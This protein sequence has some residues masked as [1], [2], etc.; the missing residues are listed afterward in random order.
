MKKRK[1]IKNKCYILLLIFTFLCSLNVYSQDK[2]FNSVFTNVGGLTIPTDHYPQTMIKKYITQYT[3][4]FGK[5]QLY[6]ILDKGEKYRL[7]IRQELKK[8]NMPEILEYLPIVESDYNPTAVSKSGAKGLWQFMENSIKPFL[9]KTEWI[10]ERYDPWKSTDAALSKLQDNYNLFKD[11]PIA[12]AAYNCGAGAMTRILNNAETKTF[13]YISEKELLRD[14]SVQYVPKLIAICELINNNEKY[15]ITLP[16]LSKSK[17]YAEYD[18]ITINQKISLQRLAT[19]LRIEEKTLKELNLALIQNCTPPNYLYKLRL[20]SGLKESATIAIQKITANTTNAYITH[21]ISKGETLWSIAKTHKV[22]IKE[23]CKINNISEN[24]I[25][26]LGKTLYIP[27][28]NT[29]NKTK[30]F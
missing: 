11:W 6:E 22:S 1:R 16:E 4:S 2:Q 7:Y 26:E 3:S 23:I 20:P 21:K 25:L 29:D 24:H 28:K 9:E 5:K 27:K 10:D 15:N 13:W 19:E 12:I 14:Q 17:R 18:Y 8:R 30:E